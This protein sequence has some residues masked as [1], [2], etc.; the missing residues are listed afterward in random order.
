MKPAVIVAVVV[1]SALDAACG[2]STPSSSSVTFNK[3]IAPILFTQC[4][5]CH[6]PGQAAPFSL[7]SYADAAPR[8]QRL[9]AAVEA[10]RMPPW[11]PTL[12]ETPVFA[13]ERRLSREQIA[14]V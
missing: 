8:A 4:A 6:R 7:L 11:L 10:R 13:D 3:D 2:T 14:T 12:D 9:A 5:P 1:V